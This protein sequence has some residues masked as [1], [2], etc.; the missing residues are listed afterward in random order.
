MKL[1]NTT[2]FSDWFLRRMVAW[3]CRQ[4]GL[5]VRRLI[6]A[7][8]KRTKQPYSGMAWGRRIVVRIGEPWHFPFGPD[9]RP[10]MQGEILAD[11][12]E[13]VVAITAHEVEHCCQRFEN[14]HHK[15]DGKRALERAT[16]TVEI[17]CLRAFRANRESLLAEWN[18]P[19]KARA[20]KPKPSRAEQ[21]EA[22]ARAMLDRWER[23]LAIAKTKAAAWRR[24][25]RRYDR[26]AAATIGERKDEHGHHRA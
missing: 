5:P 19:P 16:R 2:D 11:R 17:A 14:R 9:K 15:L 22:H 8:F 13:A 3:C 6:T 21:N 23:K 7:E 4:C 1:K 25:V 12:F 24:K 26:I 18:K 10:G 20:Q